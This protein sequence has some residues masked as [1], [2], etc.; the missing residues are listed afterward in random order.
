MATNA[1]GSTFE[2]ALHVVDC[3][4]SIIGVASAKWERWLMERQRL[5]SRDELGPAKDGEDKRGYAT[6]FCVIIISW[7]AVIPMK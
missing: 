2:E 6:A 7:A 4:C 3:L 5:Y 1:P